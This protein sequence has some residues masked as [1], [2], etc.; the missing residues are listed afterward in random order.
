MNRFLWCH[1]LFL[2]DLHHDS[3]GCSDRAFAQKQN[4]AFFL[5]RGPATVEKRGANFYLLKIDTKH[6]VSD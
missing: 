2:V 4:L 6:N 1:F 3:L 5:G